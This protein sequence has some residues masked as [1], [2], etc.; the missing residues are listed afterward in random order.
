MQYPDNLDEEKAMKRWR[1][2]I[3]QASSLISSIFEDG[4]LKVMT[5]DELSDELIKRGVSYDDLEDKPSGRS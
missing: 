1:E 2:A 5:D 4:K 3:Q